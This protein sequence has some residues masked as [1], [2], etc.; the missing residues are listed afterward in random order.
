MNH[1][2]RRRLALASIAAATAACGDAGTASH[3]TVR[4]S[5]GITIVENAAPDS[6]SETW[7]SVG[8]PVTSIGGAE[9]EGGSAL[10]RVASALRLADGGVVV[11]DGGSA[12]LRFFDAA[13]NWVRTA[14]HKGEGPG[15]FQRFGIL[16]WGPGDS[17]IVYDGGLRRVSM[18]GSDGTFGRDFQLGGGSG[19][20]VARLADGGLV[21]T[22]SVRVASDE[23][24]TSGL[25]R[26]DMYV[27]VYD[28]LG[29][30]TDTLGVF[31]A[32][33]RGVAV[34]SS[35]GQIT[36]ISIFAQS[37]YHNTGVGA[38]DDHVIVGTQ[39][40]PE[41]RVYG[42]DG[43][44]TRIVRAGGEVIAA[45]DETMA[46]FIERSVAQAQPERQVDLRKSM[47]AA[48]RP[49]FM[50][51]LG[52]FVIDRDRRIWVAD[53]DVGTAGPTDWTVFDAEGRRIARIRMPATYRLLDAGTDWIVGIER[54]DLDVERVTVRPI[55]PAG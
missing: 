39:D 17:L 47:E 24:M 52:G 7:W 38:L 9:A 53:P 5:A 22:T 26:P 23:S 10:F 3:T 30:A 19:T 54:D 50:P 48:P 36:S 55:A 34:Q 37:W 29:S 18:L 1:M 41:L 25:M 4:D 35:N 46:P 43:A 28:G 2:L 51:A 6:A 13:G 33:E 11:A 32:A 15:E 20:L 14:G 12:E 21:G 31:P 42:R 49:E 40:Q 44:L 27:I 16:A 8:S 45:T